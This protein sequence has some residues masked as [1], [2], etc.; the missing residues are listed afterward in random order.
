LRKQQSCETKRLQ[1]H[2]KKGERPDRLEVASLSRSG[3]EQKEVP[4]VTSLRR[5]WQK[6]VPSKQRKESTHRG[7]SLFREGS[8]N[9]LAGPTSG[10]VR[11]GAGELRRLT[12][13]SHPKRVLRSVRLQSFEKLKGLGMCSRHLQNRATGRGVLGAKTG[14]GGDLKRPPA[15]CLTQGGGSKAGVHP[16]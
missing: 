7:A 1:C 6:E 12:N 10:A 3:L 8:G 9:A 4:P 2:L 11:A 13:G 15:G 16:A 5:N 14:L